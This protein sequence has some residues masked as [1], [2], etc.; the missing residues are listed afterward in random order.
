MAAGRRH[1]R[2]PHGH[3]DRLD[4]RQDLANLQVLG[5]KACVSAGP[6]AQ[7]DRLS[8]IQQRVPAM[9]VSMVAV[10]ARPK[11]RQVRAGLRVCTS[12]VIMKPFSRRVR[13]RVQAPILWGIWP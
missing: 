5:G 13:C 7:R 4:D 9:N 1:Q 12:A 2:R 6:D 8:E 3:D 10:P 11:V